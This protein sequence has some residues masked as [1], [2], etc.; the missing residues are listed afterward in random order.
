MAKEKYPVVISAFLLN[1][2]SCVFYAKEK[3]WVENINEA[4]IIE[5]AEELESKLTLAK[6]SV[7]EN[8]VNEVYTIDVSIDESKNVQP[9]DIREKI[10]VNGPSIDLGKFYPAMNE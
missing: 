7:D 4:A 3:T 5:S 8:Y 9:I 6:R 2:G 10:R 1:E